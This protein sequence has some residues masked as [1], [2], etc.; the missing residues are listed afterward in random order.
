MCS[1]ELFLELRSFDFADENEQFVD[2]SVHVSEGIDVHGIVK[3]LTVADA[4]SAGPYYNVSIIRGKDAYY[5]LN[6]MF[7]YCFCALLSFSSSASDLRFSYPK[8][9]LKLV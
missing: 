3:T 6:L 2:Y 7:W 8:I 1:S 4:F 5:I 9:R